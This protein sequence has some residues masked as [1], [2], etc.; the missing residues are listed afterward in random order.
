MI[1]TALVLFGA[2]ITLNVYNFIWYAGS[3]F[4]VFM[5][6]LNIVI[7]VFITVVQLLGFNPEGSL[8]TTGSLSLYM[9]YMIWSAQLSG[10]ATHNLLLTHK[11]ANIA[12]ISIGFFLLVVVLFYLTFMTNR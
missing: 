5:N 11:D 9:T 6:I 7:I 3:A 12:E 8:I 10:S 2:T 4:N 1:F